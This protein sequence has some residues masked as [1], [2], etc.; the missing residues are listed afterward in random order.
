MNVAR[1]LVF[2]A[3]TAALWGGEGKWTPQQVLQLDP[4]WLKQ[5]GLMLPASRLWDPRQG[6]GLLAGAVNIGGCSA[7]FVSET[8]LILTNHHCLFGIL[9]EHSRPDRDL[10]TNGFLARNRGEELP[11]KTTRVLVPRHFTDV[12][13]EMEAAVPAGAD[14]AKRFSAIEDAQKRAVAECETKPGARCRVAQ[15]D[16]GLQYVLVEYFELKDVRLVYAPPR[17]VG[18]YGGEIDNWSWPRHTGDFAMARAY[19][20]PDGS[21]A[22]YSRDNVPYKPAFFFPIS[23]AGVQPGDFVMVLG[24]PGTTVRS[25]TAAEMADRRDNFYQRRIEVYGEWIRL[26]EETTKSDPAGTIAVAA[27]LKSLN[28]AFKNAQGQIAGLKRGH[29]IEKQ[30]AAD[31]EV[32]RWAAGK[33]EWKDA[34]AAKQEL[35]RFVEERR[36]S[37]ARDFLFSVLPNGPLALKHA[38]QL[39]RAAQ[40]RRKPDAEREPDYMDRELPRLR[41]R[42]EREQKSFFANSDQALLLSFAGHA[43]QL[44]QAGTKEAVAALYAGTKVTNAAERARMLD[45]STE[46]LKARHDPMLDLAFSLEPELRAWKLATERRDGAIARLR[47]LWRKAVIAHA[48]KPVA[49]D[50]N[51]TLRVS[52]A[53]VAGYA[54]RDG[55]LYTPQ[56]TLGGMLERYTGEEP[57]DLPAKLRAA[58]EAKKF[59]RWKDARLN[60]VPLN[61]L[62]DADTTGGNSGSPTVNGRGELVGLNFDRV[63][64]NVANDFGYNPDIARNVNVDIRFFLWLIEEVEG[65][66]TILRELGVRR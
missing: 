7:G 50:A 9:Q 8:G 15:F 48:G 16:G 6:T 23:T 43:L 2:F 30:R 22:S 19:V 5:Q 62:A 42:M 11:S 46:Q 39:V 27:T 31:E 36:A 57:F 66:D 4:A 20:A 54:P 32:A 38:T 52:F 65:A 60:D 18:E 58:A 29:I 17:A 51:G 35:D 13:K 10:I 44:P 24:Y 55:V 21:P 40:E 3:A 37:A 34:L 33:P 45:E 26:L 47:P 61:F 12:T 14:D 63:W 1:V 28:N 59:G 64:E 56:T 53:H 41:D 25:M 49:P